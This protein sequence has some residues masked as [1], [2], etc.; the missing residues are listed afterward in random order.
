MV[1][2][3]R[4]NSSDTDF[5][6]LTTLLDLGLNEHYGAQQSKYDT[7]NV[8]VSLNTVVVARVDGTPAGCGCFKQFDKDTIEIKRMFV[9]T[10]Q[11]GRGI[12]TTILAELERWAVDLGFSRA[13]LETGNK[14][15][16]AIHLYEKNGYKP[17]DNFAQYVGFE[18]SVCFAKNLR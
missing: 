13:I 16:E 15:I 18:E 3:V 2:V 9:K 4:T 1:T 17:I 12:A 7:F 11:R 6:N 10:E 14:Q 5:K 8:V